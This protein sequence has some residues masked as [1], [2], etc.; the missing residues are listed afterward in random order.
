MIELLIAPAVAL[1]AFV[2][3]RLALGAVEKQRT[4]FTRHASATLADLFVFLDP[5]QVWWMAF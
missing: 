5:K 4:Q 3:A 2:F 1:A